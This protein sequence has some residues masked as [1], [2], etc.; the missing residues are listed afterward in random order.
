MGIELPPPNVH[1]VA[2]RVCIQTQIRE[3]STCN[4]MHENEGRP[5]DR[6]NSKGDANTY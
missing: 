3:K 1:E 2:R 4:T 5:L 6:P